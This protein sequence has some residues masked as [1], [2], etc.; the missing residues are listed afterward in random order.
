MRTTQELIF[1][2][3]IRI[4][5]TQGV[6][7][8]LILI[9]SWV[10]YVYQQAG[11]FEGFASNI[12]TM[13]VDFLIP[14]IRRPA[15][16]VDL[17][18]IMERH[19]FLVHRRMDGLTKFSRGEGPLDVEFISRELGAG[20]TV[21]YKVENLGIIVEGLRHLDVLINHTTELGVRSFAVRVPLPQAYVLH[22]LMINS[23]RGVK[24]DKDLTAVQELLPFI[25]KSPGEM[26]KLMEIYNGLTKKERL[27]VD[28][29][30]KDNFIRLFG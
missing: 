15:K 23:K 2:E 27:L 30:C 16:K 19:N 29:T 22:K 3:T 20:Q 11:Y 12:R 6:L 21:P 18:G 7:Q 9:G 5:Q 14:N 28:K 1:W 10:E 25:K 26:S 8:N 17:C 24:K 4:L 13:D